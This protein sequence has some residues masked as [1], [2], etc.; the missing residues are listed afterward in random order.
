MDI[1]TEKLYSFLKDKIK[2]NQEENKMGIKTFI[3]ETVE[4]NFGYGDVLVGPGTLEA[5]GTVGELV[6]IQSPY[7]KPVGEYLS[8]DEAGSVNRDAADIKLTFTNKE[9]VDILI[10]NL[11]RVKVLMTLGKYKEGEE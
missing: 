11:Q 9:S 5:D 3:D 7:Q 2:V 4:V 8:H 1:F 10:N 6:I